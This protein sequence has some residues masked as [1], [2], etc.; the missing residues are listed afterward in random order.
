[1]NRLSEELKQA[2][3]RAVYSYNDWRHRGG[4]ER[5]VQI[6]SNPKHFTIG[7]VCNLVLNFDNEKLPDDL[8]G[9]VLRLRISKTKRQTLT[10]NLG[11]D[12]SYHAGARFLRELILDYH[13]KSSGAPPIS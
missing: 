7:E 2:F 5:L 1:M 12:R 9:G 13:A 11:S 6:G 10:E 3:E 8:Y 4:P